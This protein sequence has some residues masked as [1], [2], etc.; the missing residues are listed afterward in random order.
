MG[1]RPVRLPSKA[2]HQVSGFA[3]ERICLSP[4]PTPL[5]RVFHHPDGLAS[6]VTP[7]LHLGGA[8]ILTGF[9]SATPF[10]LTLGPG[11]PWADEPSPGNLGLSAR[12]I[13]TPFVATYAGILS[14][15]PSSAPR[16]TPSSGK[17]RSPTTEYLPQ[18]IQSVASVADLSPATFSA[19]RRSTS[20]LLRTL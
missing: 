16:G 12:G 2:P 3:R 14:S 17:E 15:L 6:C 10:G 7:S 5:D 4:P 1:H 19:Q 11:L 9:P 8:G 13:L 18:G 20:E